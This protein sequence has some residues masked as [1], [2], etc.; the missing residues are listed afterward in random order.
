MS[1]LWN[2]PQKVS[3]STFFEGRTLITELNDS[4]YGYIT[5]TF[6]KW[7]TE[8]VVPNYAFPNIVV[9]GDESTGKS[10]LLENITKCKIFPRDSKT[11]TRCPIRLRLSDGDPNCSVRFMNSVTRK[12][13]IFRDIE[14]EKIHDK[15][16]WIMDRIPE[17][18]VSFDE[19]EI[20]IVDHSLPRIEVVDLP[21]FR[22]YP[23]KL[24]KSIKLLC[25]KYVE[26]INTIC[27]AVVPATIPR[28]TGQQS[29]AQIQEF[30]AEDRTIVALTMVDKLQIVDIKEKMIDRITGESDEFGKLSSA[31]CVAISNRTHYDSISMKD[32]DEYESTWFR[33][34]VINWIPSSID[35]SVKKAIV[36]NLGTKNLLRK[37]KTLYSEHI[38]TEWLPTM[39]SSIEEKIAEETGKKAI[40]DDFTLNND[41]LN[42]YLEN[43]M[44]NIMN[45]YCDTDIFPKE[46]DQRIKDASLCQKIE[47][48]LKYEQYIVQL[49]TYM[50]EC[51]FDTLLKQ[52]ENIFDFDDEWDM[53]RFDVIKEK[54]LRTTKLRL[55]DCAS[56]EH[57][58]IQTLVKDNLDTMFMNDHFHAVTYDSIRTRINNLFKKYVLYP[59]LIFP[60]KY[61]D[62]EYV[63][64]PA[65][66]GRR[67]AINK[68]I[69]DLN[70]DLQNL[71]K[72]SEDVNAF[73]KFDKRDVPDNV[74]TDSAESVTSDDPEILP[75]NTQPTNTSSVNEDSASTFVANAGS[76]TLI[77]LDPSFETNFGL[78]IIEQTQ[79]LDSTPQYE[80]QIVSLMESFLIP[81]IGS[82][83]ND[84]VHNTEQIL[85]PISLNPED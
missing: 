2:V 39:I 84:S 14:K 73:V 62:E 75:T 54:L 85:S 9:I 58:Q 32:Q 38:K 59:A 47:I 57:K 24:A 42:Y 52:I 1:S 19:I 13:K 51:T 60:I 21:G 37:V 77:T 30:G 44:M 69:S 74:S 66:A 63:E 34:N 81:H 23:P 15:V 36:D 43:Q 22:A 41:K 17:N 56:R 12:K 49:C 48:C 64:N 45:T 16:K 83:S 10:S 28:F 76:K 72:L 31:K 8:E 61:T 27:I 40:L 53:G 82:K 46:K 20:N 68:K 50:C 65:F 70:R 78:G 18:T 7:F 71:L 79:P 25:E 3:E 67:T 6:D 29:I 5:K 80:P 35:N 26:D 4:V 33:Q 11:C 55:I